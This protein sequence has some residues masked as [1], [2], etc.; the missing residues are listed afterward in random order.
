VALKFDD[1]VGNADAVRKLKL[2]YSPAKADRFAQVADIAVIGPSGNGKT[3]I[4]EIAAEDIG[5]KFMKINSTAVKNPFVVRGILSAPP[6]EGMVILFDECHQLPKKLQDALLTA[7]EPGKDGKRV[8]T[9]SHKD[10]VMNDS[11]PANISFA[12]ATTNESYFRPALRNRLERIEI[13][14][15]SMVEREEIARK[16]LARHF[17]LSASEIDPQAIRDLAFRSRSGRE[18]VGNCN[19]IILLLR[20]RKE[21]KITT[22]IVKEGFKYIGIDSLGL[23]KTD[24]RLLSFLARVNTFVGLETLEAAMNM[25][26]ADIK[27]NIEPFL[28]REGFLMRQ[29]AG[30][31]ITDKGKLAVKAGS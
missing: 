13:H 31:I 18:T 2:L 24:R 14:E 23:T 25:P 16:Y 3:T 29:A 28:L 7:I 22:D 17:N 21:D 27:S 10:I 8:L 4:V 20:E 9:T 6:T 1:F 30:R 11:L 26:K 15:Y 12:F 5:R 19:T